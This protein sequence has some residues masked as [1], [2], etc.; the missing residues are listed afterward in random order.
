ME[1]VE[2]FPYK[3]RSI[4]V[5]CIVGGFLFGLSQLSRKDVS[6][7]DQGGVAAR[8]PARIRVQGYVHVKFINDVSVAGLPLP[9]SCRPRAP[10]KV[11]VR[12]GLSLGSGWS[13]PACKIQIDHTL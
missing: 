2:V 11:G 4:R 3:H 5:Y 7:I 6:K 10:Q 9:T 1:R 13:G 12:L 8:M